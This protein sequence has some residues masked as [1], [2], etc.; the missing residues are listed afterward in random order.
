VAKLKVIK[1]NT[2]RRRLSPTVR[3]QQIV[4]EAI[5]FFAEV[6]FGG[7]TRELAKRIGITQPLLYRYFPTKEELIERVFDEV[8]VRPLDRSWAERILDRSMSLE[9]RLKNFY[10]EYA[11]TVHRYEWIRIYMF[12]GLKGDPVNR[13]YIRMIEDEF[14]KPMCGEIRHHC[15][16]PTLESIPIGEIELEQL[17]ILHGGLFYYAVRKNIFHSRVNNDYAKV[18]VS[19]IEV[20]LEG[21]KATYNGGKRNE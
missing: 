3:E 15:N 16:L 1:E 4:D 5:Q 19:A 20:F 7:R 17:W 2:K 6:G 11:E 13:R 21:I 18:V 9:E 12:S 14:L 10:I 8:F